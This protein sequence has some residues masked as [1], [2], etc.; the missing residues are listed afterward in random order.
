[1]RREKTEIER[2]K[3]YYSP[4][5]T[6]YMKMKHMRNILSEYFLLIAI[7]WKSKR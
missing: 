1:M 6:F 2:L 3:E 5:K 4:C 7:F